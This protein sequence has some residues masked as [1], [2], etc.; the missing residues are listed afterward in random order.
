MFFCPVLYSLLIHTLP[1]ISGVFFCTF[2]PVTRFSVPL[3]LIIIFYYI[4]LLFIF[5]TFSFNYFYIILSLNGNLIFALDTIYCF[6][7]NTYIFVSFLLCRTSL[8]LNTSLYIRFKIALEHFFVVVT[9]KFLLRCIA[10]PNTWHFLAYNFT[11]Y[12]LSLYF[13]YLHSFLP[14]L[15]SLYN[16]HF[17]A[18]Y[19]LSLFY[20]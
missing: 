3:Y 2:E 10:Y 17:S 7:I 1:S 19:F 15:F 11:C 12:K 8:Y 5:S 20:M 9:F 13:H 6:H 4:S 16:T 14:L 18:M